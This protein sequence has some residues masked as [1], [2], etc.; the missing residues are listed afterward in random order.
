MFRLTTD[1]PSDN[2]MTALNLFYAKDGQAWVR[3]GG[4]APDY[5]DVTLNEFIRSCLDIHLPDYEWENLPDEDLAELMADW[6]LDGHTCR[7]GLMAT[8]YTAG[9]AFAEIRARLKHYEDIG[10]SPEHVKEM[11]DDATAMSKELPR[12]EAVQEKKEREN[13][14]PR[15]NADRIRTMNDEELAKLLMDSPD[16]PC[17][18]KMTPTCNDCEPCILEWLRR[19]VKEK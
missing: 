17:D 15:T 7:E 16:I 5:K 3:G 9:W 1:N 6:L 11:L 13:Q 4:P 19:P 12:V 2:L 8:L 18:E 10:L 14:K